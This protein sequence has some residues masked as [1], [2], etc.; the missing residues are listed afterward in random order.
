MRSCVNVSVFTSV[1]KYGMQI[2]TIHYSS[3][4]ID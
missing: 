3:A 4:C 2:K 1:Q